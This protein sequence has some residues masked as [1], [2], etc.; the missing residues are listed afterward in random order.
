MSPFAND[1]RLVVQSAKREMK[2]LAIRA[3]RSENTTES[4]E[5]GN[6]GSKSYQE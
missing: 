5:M 2:T 3:A 1:L 4:A 6:A